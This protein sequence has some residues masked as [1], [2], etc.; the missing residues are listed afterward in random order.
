MRD[1]HTAIVF[2]GSALLLVMAFSCSVPLPSIPDFL[3]MFLAFCFLIG[4]VLQLVLGL[5]FWFYGERD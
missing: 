4:A 2:W 5:V 1:K 3:S